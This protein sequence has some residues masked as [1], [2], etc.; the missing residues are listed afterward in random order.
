MRFGSL[1]DVRA[2]CAT[3]RRN[4][5]RGVRPFL[6]V[7]VAAYR[8]WGQ[9]DPGSAGEGGKQPRQCRDVLVL[10]DGAGSA[11]EARVRNASESVVEAS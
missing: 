8:S 3:R 1:L 4:V 2:V 5:E 6:W 9:P 11:S 7:V 10:P